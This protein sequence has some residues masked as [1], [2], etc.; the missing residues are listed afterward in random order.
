MDNKKEFE[1]PSV[2]S[3]TVAE[4]SKKL[5]EVNKK[6]KDSENE[7]TK[8]IENISHD[9]RA[10]L[11]AI[12]STVDYLMQK[13]HGQQIDITSEEI[14]S[15]LRLM[16]RRVRALENM[17]HDLYLL[18]CIDSGREEFKFKEIPF[19]QFLEEYYYSVE[20]DDKYEG[21]ELVMDIPED[22]DTLVKL[23]PEKMSRVLDNLFT[24]ARKY[25]AV[26]SRITLGASQNGDMLSFYVEDTGSGIPEDAI[27]YV[28]DRTYRV[29]G[30]RTPSED[31]GSGLGLAISKSVVTAHDGEIKCES[32]LGKGSKFT[33]YLPK[34]N[35]M[36]EANG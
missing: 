14:R 31:S 11:T 7:R 33:V 8:M 15:M 24:N 16:D 30:A 9:L 19:F 3:D 1:Q 29:S 25:S 26:G 17:V 10:P 32:T 22:I 34:V 2:V 35:N 4:L 28:F 6:L 20:M 21:Y 12:R 36:D 13:S 27:P 23:D 5:I 18:T